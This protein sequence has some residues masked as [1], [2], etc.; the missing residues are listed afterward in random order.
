MIFRKIKRYQMRYS[1]E[2]SLYVGSSIFL[3]NGHSGSFDFICQQTELFSFFLSIFVW[4]SDWKF[5]KSCLPSFRLK[6]NSFTEPS[7]TA[8]RKP[9]THDCFVTSSSAPFNRLTLDLC[10]CF[11][12]QPY[13]LCAHRLVISIDSQPVWVEYTLF[14]FLS[15]VWETNSARN[16][17]WNVLFRF[18]LYSLSCSL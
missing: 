18:A 11:P 4:I 10:L 13:P 8:I 9:A 15:F 14:R 5:K 1:F 16:R 2:F 3:N 6:T 7:A 17:S 12:P